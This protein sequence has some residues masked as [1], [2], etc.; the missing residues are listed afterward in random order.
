MRIINKV[1]FREPTTCLFI[2]STVLTFHDM[3]RLRIVKI[4]S[5]IVNKHILVVLF[6]LREG[7]YHSSM[8]MFLIRKA[9]TNVKYRCVS[10]L[11][12]KLWNGINDGLQLC[13]SLLE[14][15]KTLMGKIMKDDM[16][17]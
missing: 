6:R 15:R 3:V 10:V 4:M 5:R 13:D 11:G 17:N 7:K 12:V 8:L 9:R 14:F 2:Q 1:G 16:V